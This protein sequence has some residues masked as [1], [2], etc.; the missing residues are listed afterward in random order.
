MRSHVEQ[1]LAAGGGVG[2][3]IPS[4]APQSAT[5]LPEWA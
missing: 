2:W 5:T 4:A 1:S 3:I